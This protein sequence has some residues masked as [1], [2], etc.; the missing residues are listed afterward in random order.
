VAEFS[1]AD[2]AFTGFRIVAAR[3]W[4]VLV[5]AAVQFVFALAVAAFITVSAGAAFSQLVD[6][7]PQSALHDS[8][9]GM[10]LLRQV[11]PTYVVVMLAALVYYAVFYAAMNRAVFKPQESRFGYLRLAS[12]ELRQLGL[13][14]LM[15]AFGIAIYFGAAPI[16]AIVMVIIELAGGQAVAAP[17]A[18]LA[19]V[20]ALFLL[21]V[22]LVT[23]FWLASPLTFAGARITLIG[24]WRL[25]RG[26]FW[27][28]LGTLLIAVALSIVVISLTLAI[29]VAA[30]AVLGGVG[31][32]EPVLRPDTSSL[33]A[34]FTPAR[35]IYLAISAVGSALSAPVLMTPP[36]AILEAVTNARSTGATLTSAP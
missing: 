23:R 9:R 25:T 4:L 10:D 34:V 19:M 27:P 30:V 26:R 29:A 15:A 22:F 1:V 17:L 8:G 31:A 12:D 11:A 5:W 3:P 35:L 6:F 24:S 13:F 20:L 18:V 2:A 21:L 7:S 33:S 28:V 14:A 36:A 16:A 32:L